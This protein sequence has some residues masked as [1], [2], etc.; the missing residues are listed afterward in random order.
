MGCD[1]AVSKADTANRTSFTVGGLTVDNLTCIVDQRVGRWGTDEWIDVLFEIE[2]RWRPELFFVEGGVIWN[3]VAPT[4]YREMRLRGKWLNFLPINPIKDKATRGRSY[5]KRMRSGSVRFDKDT[6]EKAK[7]LAAGEAVIHSVKP[8]DQVVKIVY[9]GL[10][11]MLGGEEPTPIN[12]NA[13]PPAVTIS[14]SPLI[15][16]RALPICAKRLT[17]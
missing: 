6:I 10:V 17:I 12:L 5:Q 2:T 4:L 8:A 7:E 14:I 13:T 9:D 16:K 11:E 15:T 3:A 1:F